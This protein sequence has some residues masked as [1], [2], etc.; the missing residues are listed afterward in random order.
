MFTDFAMLPP[1]I[2]SGLIYSGPGA[3]SLRA[4]ATTWDQLAAELQSSAEK[5]R[6]VLSD[7]T[8]VHWHGP[9]SAAMTAAATPY[10]NWLTTSAAQASQTATQAWSAVAAFEQARAM[11][12]PPP[13]VS[14]NRTQMASLTATN[15]FGQNTPAI[16]ATE[17]AYAEMWAQDATAMY[18]YSGASAAATK[19]T[20]FTSPQQAVNPA[21]LTAQHTAVAQAATDAAA[22]A[23]AAALPGGII[24]SGILLPEDFV[25][26]DG[27][28]AVF[29][30]MSA[31]RN[32]FA[33]VNGALGNHKMISELTKATATASESAPRGLAAGLSSANL[34]SEVSRGGLSAGGLGGGVSAAMRGAGSIGPMSV[35]AAWAAPAAANVTVL[36]H[37]PL[38]TLPTSEAAEAAGS[39]MP[40]IPG[41]AMTGSGR[42]GIVPRYGARLTVM[43]RPLSGG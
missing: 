16:T 6:T 20:P 43:A 12:V 41:V 18:G 33:L 4:A 31:T 8:S 29:S 35:P 34:V 38:T 27:I 5:Y 22:T 17:A 23:P 13:V 25:A 11:T 39:G 37:T 10:V 24:P 28:L 42:G 7:L 2:N 15:F 40:G 1:E 30:G 9:A 3:G 36:S 14:A 21:G 19:L 32:G 26:L